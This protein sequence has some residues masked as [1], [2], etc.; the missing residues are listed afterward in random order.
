MLDSYHRPK[1]FWI[2][3]KQ[4]RYIKIQ[5]RECSAWLRTSSLTASIRHVNV[6]VF[7]IRSTISSTFF[8]GLRR[9]RRGWAGYTLTAGNQSYFSAWLKLQKNIGGLWN[10]FRYLPLDCSVGWF[11]SLGAGGLPCLV[12]IRF[13][14][15]GHLLRRCFRLLKALGFDKSLELFECQDARRSVE[16]RRNCNTTRSLMRAASPH[17]CVDRVILIAHL[18]FLSKSNAFTTLP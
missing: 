14:G 1:S 5:L 4:I 9:A 11:Y 17:S 3:G 15:A 7:D 12:K 2:H 6:R 8:S 13:I 18:D 10:C 16:V